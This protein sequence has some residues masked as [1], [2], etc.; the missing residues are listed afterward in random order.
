LVAKIYFVNFSI[1][2]FEKEKRKLSENDE[3]KEFNED[4]ISL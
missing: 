4:G 1:L 2:D 3:I